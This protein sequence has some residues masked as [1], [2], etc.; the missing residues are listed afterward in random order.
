MRVLVLGGG[1]MGV[2]TACALAR[3]GHEVAVL[4]RAAGPAEGSS[5]ANAGLV[6]PSHAYSWAAPGA[7]WNLLKS[8][9]Q[10]D[11]PIRLRLKSDP[12]FWS[13]C[14]DFLRQCTADRFRANTLAKYR[15]CRYSQE[16]LHEVAAETGIDYQG[17]RKG[18]LYLYRSRES[19]DR[20]VAGGALLRGEG[21]V[22]EALDFDGVAARE[23][24]L[25]AARGRIAG[26]LYC[27]T[28]ESGDARLFT[29][30]L[31]EVC[32]T[33]GVSFEWNRTIQGLETEGD[34]VVGVV[35]DGGVRSADAY[36]LA[37]GVQAPVLARS[38]GV[39]LPVYPVK[40]YSVTLP[41]GKGAPDMGGVEKD[42]FVA[43]ARFGDRLRLTATAEFDGYD[44]N[45]RTDNFRGMWTVGRE[46]FPEAADWSRPTY[47]AGLRPMTPSG[48]PILGRGRHANLWFNTGQGHMGWTMSCGSA[49]ITADLIAGRAPAIDLTGMT[50]EARPG[51]RT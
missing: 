20:A 22:L 23:P 26:G 2:T 34:R 5:F 12:A 50:L 17:T 37:L 6:A 11:P 41:A 51:V 19:L 15:L 7:P 4:D 35:T 1:L 21:Q 39:R 45:H 40:G 32:R 38:L 9:F 28:D 29:L 44:L 42:R 8:L 24:A 49:R 16:V 25:E 46:L 31:A 47:W 14:L 18:L 3:D 13:W 36:V 43:W 27:P 10:D 48:A 33:L 30:G